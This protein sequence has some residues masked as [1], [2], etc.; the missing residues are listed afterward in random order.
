[1]PDECFTLWGELK[2]GLMVAVLTYQESLEII[3]VEKIKTVAT[4]SGTL[5]NHNKI[6]N[7]GEYIVDMELNSSL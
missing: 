3:N 5:F 4:V 7:D 6:A 1:M 2:D